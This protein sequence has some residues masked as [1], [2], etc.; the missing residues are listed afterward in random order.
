MKETRQT[1]VRDPF[2]LGTWVKMDVTADPSRNTYVA[3]GTVDPEEANLQAIALFGDAEPV[4]GTSQ[5]PPD[6]FDYRFE[7]TLTENLPVTLVIFSTA[8]GETDV[9]QIHTT[10]GPTC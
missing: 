8:G 6:G 1:V 7:F 4:V 5:E 9:E 3:V 10:T 2:E